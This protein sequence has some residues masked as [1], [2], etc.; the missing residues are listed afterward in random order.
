[1]RT[2]ATLDF[3]FT[4]SRLNTACTTFGTG[5]I[6]VFVSRILMKAAVF[7]KIGDPCQDDVLAVFDDVAQ[8]TV[9]AGEILIRVKAAAMNPLDWKLIRGE[10]PVLSMK[11]GTVVGCDVAGLVE[12]IGPNCGETSLQVGDEIFASALVNKGAF[13]EFCTVPV[14]AVYKKPKNC[15]FHE[16]ASLPCVGLT[17][18]QGLV[19]HG[20][21]KS[22]MSVCI[23]G[24]TGSVGSLAIQMAKTM[25]ASHVYAT[26]SSVD[27]LKKLG[28]DTI[29]NYKEQ[30]VADA[31]AGK[32][33]DI[34]LDTVGGIEGW[35]TA[36]RCLKK[37]G[38]FVTLVGDGGSLVPMIAGL[39]WRTAQSFFGSPKYHF[40]SSTP[41]QEDMK[42]LAEMVESGSVKPLLDSQQFELTTESIHAMFKAGLSHQTKGMLVM[43]VA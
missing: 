20:K 31:L 5:I 30:N 6:K 28:A 36:K 38:T 11:P 22:G 32:D 18:L 40:M 15:T 7:K 26:G 24:G 27:L 4:N 43:T 42:K 41:V 33:I 12:A 3:S 19:T 10:I 1:M 21:F 23:F 16:A 14:A 17:A 2:F 37:G 25:G 8:P 29:I 35:T 34:V 39:V 13:A 9:K